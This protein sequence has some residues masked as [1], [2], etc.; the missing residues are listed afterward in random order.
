MR[1]SLFI[2]LLM[3]VASCNLSVKPK[4][5][6][7]ITIE[8][9]LEDPTLE[10]RA[11]A[12]EGDKL[13]YATNQNRYGEWTISNRKWRHLQIFEADSSKQ[14]FRAIARNQ[15]RSYVLSVGNPANLYQIEAALNYKL[16]YQEK[17][18]KVF[19]DSMVFWNEK[20]GIAMGD[21]VGDCLSIII[22]RDGGNSWEKLPCGVLPKVS[23]GEAAFAASNTNIAISGNKTWIASGG[24]KSR[25]FYSPDK[26]E[27][28]GVFESPI[29][30]GLPT[31]GMY[32]IA[33]YDDEIGVAVGG[34]YTK[35]EMN[36]GTAVLTKDG[37]KTWGRIG[38]GEEPVYKSC[39]QFVPRMQ[40]KALV[41]LGKT[42]IA[43]SKDMG[44]NWKKISEESFYTFKFV[45]DTT[46]YAAGS[47]RIAKIIFK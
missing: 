8:P 20:E 26:G 11:I 9:I 28:W 32:S 47:G 15:G 3:L 24:K 22:T 14:S 1:T 42:G 41:A 21:P 33:F 4:D 29:A 2:G 38:E 6:S 44:R 39:V 12:I 23:E 16:V 5:F 25:V 19:Y 10:V 46:A 35:P 13:F 27:T 17:H 18:E 40:G 7:Q 36:L 43:Y 30:Q 34:D 31:Q 37:G 45:N